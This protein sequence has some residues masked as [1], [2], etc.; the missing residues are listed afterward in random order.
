M[1]RKLLG[2]VPLTICFVLVLTNHKYLAAP[3]VKSLKYSFCYDH[4]SQ[5]P[6][7]CLTLSMLYDKGNI[8]N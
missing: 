7:P 5:P 3:H 6:F 2:I 1:V 4:D 8:P